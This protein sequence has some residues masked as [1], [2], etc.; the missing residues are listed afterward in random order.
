MKKWSLKRLLGLML[1]VIM[2]F[3]DAAPILASALEQEGFQIVG[4]DG[5]TVSCTTNVAWEMINTSE[6]DMQSDQVTE[7][8]LPSSISESVNTDGSTTVTFSA[9]SS[10]M[11]EGRGVWWAQNSVVTLTITNGSDQELS[12]SYR[13]S[14]I[15]GY[16]GSGNI[17]LAAGESKTLTVR[18]NVSDPEQATSMQVTGSITIT[19]VSVPMDAPAV[20]FYS[21]CYGSYTYTLGENPGSIAA[22]DSIVSAEPAVTD[23]AIV[24]TWLEATVT[25]TNAEYKFVGWMVNGSLY[26][27]S[28]TLTYT[29]AGETTVYPVFTKKDDTAPF[30]VN[31]VSY[32]YWNMAMDASISSGKPVILAKDFTLPTTLADNGLTAASGY[33]SGTDGALTYTIPK[34]A[35]LLIPRNADDTNGNFNSQAA[36]TDSKSG[37][38]LFRTLTVPTG[39]TIEVNGQMNVNACQRGARGNGGYGSVSGGYAL[40]KL[41]GDSSIV[42]NSGGHLYAYG[43][44]IGSGTVDVKN[45]GNLYELLSMIDWRGG[46]ITSDWRI[47]DSRNFVLSQYYVQNVECNLIWRAGAKDTVSVTVV[48]DDSPHS[49]TLPWVASNGT[50]GMFL[51]TSGYM[52]RS[53][54]TAKDQMTYTVGEDSAMNL[55]KLK[56]DVY[57]YFKTGTLDSSKSSMYINSNMHFVVEDGATLTTNYGFRMLPG[58]SIHVEEGGHLQMKD[59]LYLY[60]NSAWVGK[61]FV[62]SGKDYRAIDYI[63]TTGAKSS[64]KVDA[65]TGSALL[66]I[67]GTA[68]AEKGIYT[69]AAAENTDLDRGITGKGSL[70]ITSQN[71]GA[72]LYEFTSGV[73]TYQTVSFVP[74]VGR[75]AGLSET[76]EDVKSFDA[77]DSYSGL[78]E[79]GYDYW[80]Q[81][82]VNVDTN[83]SQIVRVP[84]TAVKIN[85]ETATVYSINGGTARLALSGNYAAYQNG[86]ELR[87]YYN[88][89]NGVSVY[90]TADLINPISIVPAS[91]VTV[92][93]NIVNNGVVVK[94]IPAARM[95][96]GSTLEGYYTDLTCLEEAGEVVENMELFIPG[97]VWVDRQDGTAGMCYMSLA[98][99]P[100]AYL[101]VRDQVYLLADT[102]LSS[103]IEVPAGKTLN[104]NLNGK[105]ITYSTNAFNTY[106][107]L[108]LDLGED[109]KICNTTDGKSYTIQVRENGK[110]SISGAGTIEN[111]ATA[112]GVAALI[113][114]GEITSISGNVGI[115]SGS[116]YGIRN[117]GDAKIT[118]IGGSNSTITIQSTQYGIYAEGN[119]EI[120][121]IGGS[122]STI[123]VISTSSSTKEN[124]AALYMKDNAKVT[125]IG[126]SGSTI[127]IQGKQYGVFMDGNAEIGTI[128]AGNDTV[129]LE[130]TNTT[131]VDHTGLWMEENSSAYIGTMGGGNLSTVHIK[132]YRRTAMVKAGAEIGTIGT[133]GSTVNFTIT[134][135][136][137]CAGHGL[138][139]YGTIGTIGGAGSKVNI[140]GIRAYSTDNAYGL[141]LAGNVTTVGA[142]GSEITISTKS[143][144]NANARGIYVTNGGA[145]TNIGGSNPDVE[146][147][148]AKITITD[149]AYTSTNGGFGIGVGK[150]SIGS[151]GNGA[152]I[153]IKART[154]ISCGGSGEAN[155][156]TITTIGSTSGLVKITAD[157]AGI[158]TVNNTTGKTS[159]GTI[160]G[161]VEVTGKQYGIHNGATIGELGAGLVLISNGES[162]EDVTYY[163]VYNTAATE[164]VAGGKINLISGGKLYQKGGRDYIFSDGAEQMT[165]AEGYKLS[166]DATTVT[167]SNGTTTYECYAVTRPAQNTNVTIHYVEPSTGE[168]VKTETKQVLVGSVLSGY[169]TDDDCETPMT[170]AVTGNEVLYAP[171]VVKVVHADDSVDVYAT[172]ADAVAADWAEGDE[173][174]LLANIS[175]DTLLEIPEG[176]TVSLNLNGKQITYVN[177][178]FGVSG[179]LNLNLGEGGKITNTTS[180]Q[181]SAISIRETGKLS[182]S[183]NGTIENKATAGGLAVIIN[184]GEITS[185]SGTVNITSA[186]YYGI[187]NTGDAEIKTI[188]GSSS[189]IAITATQYGIYMED[190]AKIT[191]IGGSGSTISIKATRYGIYMDG[192]AKI[193][194]IGA[195]NDTV[196]LE[197]T[198]T[199]TNQTYGGLWMADN[200]TTSIGTI[201]GGNLSTV[202]IKAYRRAAT[203]GI[204]TEVGTIGTNGSTVNFTVTSS[205][206]AKTVA[207]GLYSYGTIGTIGGQ[208]SKIN[209]KGLR[210][211]N[212]TNAYGLYLHGDV[213]TIGAAGSEIT[214]TGKSV[215][216]A[217][218]RGIFV[219]NGATV[220]NIGGANPNVEGSAAKITITDSAYTSTNGGFGISAANGTIGSIGNGAEITI[221]AYAGI[222]SG[223]NSDSYVGTITNI[224]SDS[225]LI[226]I[227]AAYAGIQAINNI[228][229]QT[230]IG[231]IGGNVEVVS[232]QYGIYNGATIGELADGLV[233]ASD[234]DSSTYTVFNTAESKKTVEENGEQV[235]RTIAGGKIN[236]ISGGKFNHKLDRTYIFSD[237]AENMTYPEGCGLSNSPES[238]ILSDKSSKSCYFVKG[239]D[240]H[241]HSYEDGVCTICGAKQGIVIKKQPVDGRAELGQYATVSVEAE[242]NGLTYQWYYREANMTNW[243]KATDFTTNVYSVQLTAQRTG[244]SLYCVITDAD[245]FHVTTDTVQLIN[246]PVF[247]VDNVDFQ[248]EQWLQPLTV[249]AATYPKRTSSTTTTTYFAAGSAHQ[250]ILYSS[251]FREGT[252]ALWN[253]N[254]STYYSAVMNPASLLYTVDYS[255]RGSTQAGWSGSVC[256]TTALR[257]CGYDFP[258]TTAEIAMLFQEKTDHSINNLEVGDILW[259]SGHCAGVVGVTKDGSGNVTKVKIIEQAAYVEIFEKTA[260]QWDSYFNREWTHIY[261]GE[262]NESLKEPQVY[263]TNVSIIFERGNN[264]YVT[265]CSTMLFYIPTATTVYM[266]KNGVTTE[267]DKSS[268]PTRVV[269]N[270]TVYDLASLFTGIGDYYFHTDEDATDMCIKVIANGSITVSGNMAT[271]SGYAN[272]RPIGYRLIYITDD[273]TNYNWW[274]APEG[275]TSNY[276]RLSWERIDSNTFEIHNIPEDSDGWKIEMFY[277]TGYGWA[278]SLSD[279]IMYCDADAHEWLDAS[280]TVPRICGICSATEGEAR[281]HSYGEPTWNW[282]TTAESATC[283]ATFTCTAC[284]ATAEGAVVNVDCEVTVKDGNRVDAACGREGSVVYTATATVEFGDKTYTADSDEVVIPA[285]EHRYTDYKSIGGD[286]ERASCDH[287]CGAT[288]IRV[289]ENATS[290]ED[291]DV[292]VVPDASEDEPG[293]DESNT[294]Q[295]T[296]GKDLLSLIAGDSNNLNLHL[297]SN[298]LEL[299]FDNTALKNIVNEHSGKSKVSIVVE[300][301][302]PADATDK[303]VFDIHL[304]ADGE[305]VDRSDFGDGKVTVTIPLASLNLTDKQTVEVWYI[306]RNE[307]GTEKSRSLMEDGFNHDRTTNTVT[308]KTNHFS[309]YEVE[310]VDVEDTTGTTVSG[311][312]KAY[313]SGNAPVVKLYAGGVEKYIAEVG[314]ATASGGQY[315]WTFTFSGVAQGTYDLVVTKAGHLTYTITGVQV[316]GETLDLNA[317]SNTAIRTMSMLCGDIN[318]DGSINPTDINVIYQAGNYYKAVSV[319]ANAVADLNGDGSINPTDINIIY[320]AANYYKGV[321]NCTI[322]Y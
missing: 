105:Q 67:D 73:S 11:L 306:E 64:R 170:E 223:G 27:T 246:L 51:L 28:E 43:Y 49:A 117:L 273:A 321:V 186:S 50:E 212:T 282:S 41:N 116:T 180:G 227:T 96:A 137:G 314:A 204:G 240:D 80:Y 149:S 88:A 14:D 126:G 157:F 234:G 144:S 57:L 182:I 196:T 138:Y 298:I 63:A 32:F 242:G 238:V 288:D 276:V 90:E 112:S 167:M 200:S 300:D 254:P 100:V 309:E 75:L 192:N 195:G 159:I 71:T 271:V 281:G 220:T 95:P 119:A 101:S 241:D 270:T 53:Y 275:Y 78:G 259:V 263:P 287:N 22:G 79:D 165:Y 255:N 294:A 237:G 213:T 172:L 148:A 228:T 305:K 2:V 5:S 206:S 257:A 194:T 209:I 222:V 239:A 312:V 299:I 128:G 118:S 7:G 268:F 158:A 1:A 317:H 250:G 302:T 221:Q 92:K 258:Y 70:T 245:G 292:T 111:K 266:T 160:S 40:M 83:A 12:V 181:N 154:G 36:S 81:T 179:T 197:S 189:T 141:Y 166:D 187:R 150:G 224:G 39:I 47:Y 313:N 171:V 205:N 136:S 133:N 177:N 69:S 35:K 319:A 267:Y 45:G 106:G 4:T 163:A 272:C 142:E 15:P 131:S 264:T 236:L 29:T 274:L 98:D 311:T 248:W 103:A 135:T 145:V 121:T 9:V 155:V 199:A 87:Y 124:Y 176:K 174:F 289:A 198:S 84:G 307:D 278:R 16:V 301:T 147:G 153:T 114:K 244:R 74:A 34:G 262:I 290:D 33:I 322:A 139:S 23:S 58:S 226:K 233:L 175:Q 31:G 190:N 85:G 202:H 219:T 304:K 191:T 54:D 143:V 279:N 320:Q 215:T 164:T 113:N 252:D 146:G 243:Y 56:I 72:T 296:I 277:D 308:F 280:C 65:K 129:T 253:L 208:G 120:T 94:T 152:N 19:D 93:V 168:I 303:L 97:T 284:E 24:G 82:S 161:N 178:V 232:A 38:S 286:L 269:N 251:T 218:M 108:N 8:M 318:G 30:K 295:V 52:K 66:Q 188:G 247:R 315:T 21:S 59:A 230:S 211:Y 17:Y 13:D 134:S 207:S 203:F 214:I 76:D 125:T 132:G 107:T 285:L 201:G 102:T 60:G 183:G 210:A 235:E 3:S 77:G 55:N 109:G 104:M 156:G 265:D 18:T 217:N 10:Y 184:K 25:A 20:Y 46:S 48:A 193:T 316:T 61:G 123:S 37:P 91:T 310:I 99:V 283:T 42:V 151:I 6:P 297:Y 256:S 62:M 231:T 86:E 122:S 216:D 26:S 229:N 44:I 89:T 68:T 162:T 115:I 169:Y 127:T 173:A 185:I 110:M 293:E 260:A 130:S 140:T 249:T 261:R 225:G 291:K